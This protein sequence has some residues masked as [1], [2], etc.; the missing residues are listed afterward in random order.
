MMKAAAIVRISG[1]Q[2]DSAME[3][4]PDNNGMRSGH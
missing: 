3:H 2:Y 4:F 1:N